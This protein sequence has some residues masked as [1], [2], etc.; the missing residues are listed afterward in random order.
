M[1]VKLKLKWLEK[2]LE[3][4]L[5]KEL[6][7]KEN[8]NKQPHTNSN[9][10]SLLAIFEMISFLLKVLS[11]KFMLDVII[12]IEDYLI[13]FLQLVF[14]EVII[15][16]SKNY[17]ELLLLVFNLTKIICFTKGFSEN[18]NTNKIVT[19]RLSASQAKQVR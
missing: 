8:P 6:V 17:N 4:F 19:N 13:Q 11:Q 7:A 14:N 16:N 2:I 1:E 12:S 3:T 9:V 18:Q 15:F 10:L 5:K